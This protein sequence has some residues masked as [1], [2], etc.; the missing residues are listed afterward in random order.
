[1]RKRIDPDEFGEADDEVSKLLGNR[2]SRVLT[3]DCEERPHRP[4]RDEDGAER[5]FAKRKPKR[6]RDKT[7]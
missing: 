1:M 2:Y 6:V 5:H 7:H 3:N 4:H